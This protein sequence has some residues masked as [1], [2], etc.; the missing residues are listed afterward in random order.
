[1]LDLCNQNGST[2]SA[3]ETVAVDESAGPHART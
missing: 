1:M 2:F 3:G